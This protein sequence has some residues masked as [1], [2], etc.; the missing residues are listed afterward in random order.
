[1]SIER[2]FYEKIMDTI[3]GAM[4]FKR[5]CICRWNAGINPF[6]LS[7]DE[8]PLDCRILAVVDAYDAMTNER[9]YRKPMTHEQAIQELLENSG[10]QFDPAIVEVFVR[11]MNREHWN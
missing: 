7:K 2:S 6:G 1:M 8:I 11:I 9:P 4:P 3:D 10:T 5:T